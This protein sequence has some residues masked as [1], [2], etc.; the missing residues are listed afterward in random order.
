M[1]RK[2]SDDEKDEYRKKFGPPK[3]SNPLTYRV[4]INWTM[5]TVFLFMPMMVEY[6]LETYGI[7]IGSENVVALIDNSHEANI[8]VYAAR[9]WG[10]KGMFAVHTWIA[11]KRQ[12]STVYEVSQVIGWRRDRQGNVLFRETNIPIDSW[13]GKQATLLLDLRGEDVESII[14]KVDYAIQAYPW[15]NNYGLY[16]GPN[17][18]TFV[19]WI[20]LQVPEL[21]LDLPSTAIGKDWRPLA[22]SF[23][24]SP[25]GTGLQIS[26]YGLLGTTF[27]LKEGLEMNLLGLHFE[28]DVFDFAL[29]IPLF[30]RYEL[31]YL[32]CYFTIWYFGKRLALKLEK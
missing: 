4:L 15:K 29:E 24:V 6:G 20:G 27:G 5:I 13:W 26:L 11:M 3:Q 17:S 14:D 16:P 8:R 7:D 2:L 25:S 19:A 18:N 31:W 10:A 9:T 12:G 1:D 22:D 28:L 21:G 23:G 32:L 30:G